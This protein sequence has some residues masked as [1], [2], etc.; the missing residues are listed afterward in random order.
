MRVTSG[1]L[2][3]FV[4]ICILA[5]TALAQTQERP[6]DTA[7]VQG[8]VRDSS[9][10]SLVNATVSLCLSGGT[11]MPDTCGLS[12]P[13]QITHTDGE[14]AYRF[15]TV[16][17]G[18]YILRA[19]M[20]G[21]IFGVA[22]PVKIGD[23]EV[24]TIDLIGKLVNA[25]DNHNPTSAVV[26]GRPV[27]PANAPEFFDEPQF[28]VAGVTQA[29]NAGGHGSDTVSRTTEA[30]AK[31][32]VSLGNHN[33]NEASDSLNAPASV[34]AEN[35]L[36]DAVSRNPSDAALHHRLGDVE[37]KLDNPLEAVREYQRAA[38]LD[39]SETNLFDWG[40]ELLIHRA[41]DPAAEVFT[42]GHRLFP[43][44][45]RM[46][47][48]LGVDWYARG[49]Y[50]QAAQCLGDASDLAPD[51]PTPY[52]FLGKMQSVEI[53]PPEKSLE[54]LARFVALQPNNALANYYYAV[55]LWKQPPGSPDSD[56][57]RSARV[58]SLLQKA[59]KLDPKLSAA[60]L[61]LGI[62]YSERAD[63]PHAISAYRKAIEVGS[64]GD[65]AV[66]G[67]HYRLAQAYRRTGDKFRAQEELELHDR[68]AKKAKQDTERDHREIQEFVISLRSQNT[69]SPP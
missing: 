12:V 59:A 18:S 63:L 67:A 11:P 69:A 56:A 7:E 28:T 31:A 48:A 22:G 5:L 15:K 38:E 50:D 27:A 55:G 17:A 58:E 35:S 1:Q 29:S 14:G 43:T 51:N 46:L 39:A 33:N 4:A 6:V 53:A 10:R 54:R 13:A 25:S 40:T 36:R 2:G 42:K 61:Q 19:T 57:E 32:T 30:L 26:A 45:V 68:L 9:G 21:Y 49:S 60:Y 34:V 62:I 52:L 66:E 64:E 16:Q 23:K 47:I 3:N 65:G 8:H 37:E 41:L 20:T 24:Q 44:S